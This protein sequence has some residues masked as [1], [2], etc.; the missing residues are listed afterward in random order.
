MKRS[1]EFFE[2]CQVPTVTA[3]M[4]K[5]VVGMDR[6]PRFYDTAEL[7]AARSYF[8]DM[9]V[10]GNVRNIMLQGAVELTVQFIFPA[11][12]R[13]PE[14]TYKTTKPDTDNL[15]KAFKDAL[16]KA[17]WWKDDCQVA[18]EHVYKTYGKI[19]GIHCRAEEIN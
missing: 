5:V 6:K 10:R 15:Q 17:G 4:H 14:G 11:D 18:A 2:P 1:I 19:P 3:Q 7:K 16:T 12:G 8:F 13:H 9:A